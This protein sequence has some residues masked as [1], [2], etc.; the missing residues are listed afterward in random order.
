MGENNAFVLAEV[1]S[2]QLLLTSQCE[3]SIQSIM[4]A[5]AEVDTSSDFLML[6]VGMHLHA[7]YAIQD[8]DDVLKLCEYSTMK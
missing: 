1:G 7:V 5:S 8:E 4:N 3:D 6:V 2:L